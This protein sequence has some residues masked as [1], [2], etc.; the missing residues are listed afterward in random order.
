MFT[1]LV[2]SL[3]TARAFTV[4]P[5][6][7]RLFVEA[8]ALAADSMPGESIAVDGCCLTV[9]EIAGPVLRFD[10]LEETLRATNLGRIVAGSRV[11]LERALAANARL[12]G[13]FVQGHVDCPAAVRA[14]TAAGS[15]LGL[16]MELPPAFARYAVAKGSIA[17]N[18]VSLTIAELNA[19]DFRVWIIPHT[20]SETNLG[21]LRAG[22][23]VNLEFDLLAKYTE[24]LLAARAEPA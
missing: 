4:S 9:A 17:I 12:G 15:D 18:G 23:G 11:N 21:D 20:R 5:E 1:G 7:R 6:G 22:D 14:I 24:R 19:A 2:E 10:L 16:T 8:P 13:H 3:G